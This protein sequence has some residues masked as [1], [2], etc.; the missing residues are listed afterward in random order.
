MVTALGGVTEGDGNGARYFWVDFITNPDDGVNYIRCDAFVA[1]RFKRFDGTGAVVTGGVTATVADRAAL[2]ALN[3]SGYISYVALIYVQS[4][5]DYFQVVPAGGYTADGITLVTLSDGRIGKRLMVRD[6]FWITKQTW[7]SINTVTGSDWNTG[8]GDTMAAADASP[9]KSFKELYRRWH[10]G[11]IF[12]PRIHFSGVQADD[13]INTPPQTLYATVF[14]SA[15]GGGIHIVGEPTVIHT[16]TLTGVR[17]FTDLAGNG[18]Y[19]LADSSNTWSGQ[20]SSLTGHRMVRKVGANVRAMVLKKESTNEVSISVPDQSDPYAWWPS[21]GRADFTV[22]DA[23]EVVS[24][25]KIYDLGAPNVRVCYSQLFVQSGGG[26]HLYGVAGTFSKVK[27]LF[28][29]IQPQVDFYGV[30]DS[31]GS[32]LM[33]SSTIQ[34]QGGE[35]AWVNNAILGLDRGGGTVMNTTL[36]VKHGAMGLVETVLQDGCCDSRIGAHIRYSRVYAFDLQ[37]QDQ[38]PSVFL[39]DEDGSSEFDQPVT[40]SNISA[41]CIFNETANFGDWVGVNPTGFKLQFNAPFDT[42]QIVYIYEV[43]TPIQVFALTDVPIQLWARGG[44]IRDGY[45]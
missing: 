35:A 32:V 31:V 34:L 9:L 24:F 30:W 36:S 3:V 28:C 18:K 8:Y 38:G 2:L 4:L 11:E 25:P 5:R 1:G 37:A 7:W 33:T 16:G 21:Y 6:P 20:V 26:G 13:D 42:Q 19:I 41:Y 39:G 14:G 12:S 22:G 15:G 40:G 23:Y 44:S 43:G 17:R 10:S 29:G 27:T 45:Y